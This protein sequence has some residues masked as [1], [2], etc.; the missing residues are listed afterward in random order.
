MPPKLVGKP[1][2]AAAVKA[3]AKA[4]AAQ[5]R[6]AKVAAKAAAVAAAQAGAGA[7]AYVPPP[8][9]AGLLAGMGGAPGPLCCRA[10]LQRSC[11]LP[12][13]PERL[14]QRLLTA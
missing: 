7:G 2:G 8:W 10:R 9:V 13:W 3:K 14:H 1:K 6:A 4:A 12:P 11:R 5:A